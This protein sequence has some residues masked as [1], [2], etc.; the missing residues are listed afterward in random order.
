MKEIELCKLYLM[1]EMRPDFRDSKWLSNL[2]DVPE[3]PHVSVKDEQP[4]R[5]Q[6][7]RVKF[8]D[9][10]P[11]TWL[12]KKHWFVLTSGGIGSSSSLWSIINKNLPFRCIH[13]ENSFPSKQVESNRRTAIAETFLQSKTS[14]GSPLWIKGP[15][16]VTSLLL[17]TY[18]FFSEPF[19][20]AWSKEAQEYAKTL[21]KEIRKI[22]WT[23]RQ[24][25]AWIM[26][27]ME[28]IIKSSGADP[29]EVVLVWGNVQP[30]VGLIDALSSETGICNLLFHRDPK[31]SILSLADCETKMENVYHSHKESAFI[32]H[33]KAMFPRRCLALFCSC[34]K[35]D[36]ASDDDPPSHRET[37]KQPITIKQ[38]PGIQGKTEIFDVDVATKKLTS[39]S[40]IKE[41]GKKTNAIQVKQISGIPEPW[42][43]FHPNTF[44]KHC[45]RCQRCVHYKEWMRTI[46]LH[47]PSIV[48]GDR[49]R[50]KL[51]P[52][53]PLTSKQ[54]LEKWIL[55]GRKFVP[56]YKQPLP[57]IFRWEKEKEKGKKKIKG[58][59]ASNKDEG[60]PKKP[61]SK[62]VKSNLQALIMEEEE[63]HSVGTPLPTSSLSTDLDV[64]K[65]LPPMED[66]LIPFEKYADEEEE[67]D[68]EGDEE[69]VTL[70]E[71]EIVEG[72][73][74]DEGEEY[75]EE[76]NIKPKKQK[77]KK[78]GEDDE[79]EE[80]EEEGEAFQDPEEEDP[81]AD[82][83]EPTEDYG[84]DGY[85][86]DE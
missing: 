78:T 9:E 81:F 61:K 15:N 62:K 24:R 52:I 66:D 4:D 38:E 75:D 72:E 44:S 20:R 7:D 31:T 16:D 69:K 45:D 8:W 65:D 29:K 25:V 51:Q 54:K 63:G 47:V 11:S 77:K 27:R 23:Q 68:E 34:Q 80:L 3:S 67:D 60:K 55:P 46:M 70:D 48:W 35:S 59:D 30:E 13:F 18:P 82:H 57:N 86:D 17:S 43:S 74:S 36:F 1:G 42:N 71:P 49:E 21:G 28:Y 84:D 79:E 40:V 14:N 56:I 19:E 32:T 85:D 22:R 39:L 58:E 50:F 5:V 37:A 76:G 6:L 12:N 83:A 73:E 53:V 33:Q 64:I 26:A 41:E 2:I 10:I